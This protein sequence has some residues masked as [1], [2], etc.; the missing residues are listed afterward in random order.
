[1]C[2]PE[3]TSCG[4]NLILHTHTYNIVHIC[5]NKIRLYYLQILAFREVVA[6]YTDTRIRIID[7]LFNI[8]WS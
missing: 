4:I 7:T 1:M 3:K 8:L 5:N 6:V 2:R